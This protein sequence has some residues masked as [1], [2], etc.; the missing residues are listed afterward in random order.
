MHAERLERYLAGREWLRSADGT[1]AA[2]LAT[3]EFGIRHEQAVLD[4]FVPQ[5]GR[6]P[7]SF[8]QIWIETPHTGRSLPEMDDVAEAIGHLADLVH[9]DVIEEIHGAWPRCPRHPHPL[10]VHHADS[11]HPTWRCPKTPELEVFIGE[12]ARPGDSSAR[13]RPPAIPGA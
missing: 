12:L 4:W 3:L 10:D 11:G 2:R 7:M 8:P 6:R 5:P 9:E 1:E 13:D